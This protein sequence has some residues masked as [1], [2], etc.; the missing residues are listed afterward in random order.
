MIHKFRRKCLKVQTQ[1]RA[2]NEEQKFYE[3][4]QQKENPTTAKDASP[5][6]QATATATAPR[7]EAHDLVNDNYGEQQAAVDNTKSAVSFVTNTGN[8]NESI[9]ASTRAT[10]TLLDNVETMPQKTEANEPTTPTSSAA[11]VF[12]DKTVGAQEHCTVTRPKDEKKPLLKAAVLNFIK[13][14]PPL[15]L[16]QPLAQICDND[17]TDHTNASKKLCLDRS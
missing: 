10:T 8:T 5:A 14:S 4:Q 1:L 11:L 15:T 7:V 9:Q 3:R 13:T 16:Q 6:T 2:L 12:S 17:A